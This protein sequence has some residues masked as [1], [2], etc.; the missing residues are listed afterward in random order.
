MVK[1][2]KCDWGCH[3]EYWARLLVWCWQ[4][5]L[6]I[7]WQQWSSRFPCYDNDDSDD[8]DDDDSD[9][10]D[11]VDDD[12]DDDDLRHVI[13]WVNSRPLWIK[14]R[15][16]TLVVVHK[17]HCLEIYSDFFAAYCHWFVL[18]LGLEVAQCSI[19]RKGRHLVENKKHWMLADVNRTVSITS[20]KGNDDELLWYYEEVNVDLVC[21]IL[22]SSSVKSRKVN[23]LRK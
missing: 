7:W 1:M 21:E 2:I 17:L 16:L 15:D 3:L 8:D 20:W 18:N 5:Q 23:W 12:D 4:W 14:S 13:G 19:L 11:D 10:D 6:L 22:F 9:D